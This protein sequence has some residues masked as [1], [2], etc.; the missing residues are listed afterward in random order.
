MAVPG[1][2]EIRLGAL[3]FEKLENNYNDGLPGV[4]DTSYG[5][6]SLRD[7]TQGGN[8]YGGG[9]TYDVT[10]IESPNFPD[11][12]AGFGMGEFYSYDHD[13]QP[14][15][16]SKAMDI[17]FLLDYTFSMNGQYNDT[18]NG[19]KA[20]VNT[21]SNKVVSESG[22]DYR[23]AA[24]L[25]DQNSTTPTYW[26]GNN[27]TVSNLPSANKYN[28]GTVWLSAVVPF[29]NANKTDFDTKIGYIA[30]GDPN[31]GNNSATS[32]EIGTGVGGPEPNDTAI[33]RVLNNSL[34]GS[35]R[36]GVTRMII[37]ITDDSP[38]GD[39]DD[40]FNGA[41]ELANMGTLS[42]QAV[43]NVCTISVLGNFSNSTSS[44][45]TTTRYDIY[46]GYANNTGGLTNFAGDP[47]DIV[48]FIEDICDDIGQ[49]FPSVTT[50]D[51]SNISS[52]GFRMNGNVTA[53]GGSVVSTRGFVKSLSS[54]NLIPGAS[55][56]TSH[57]SGSGTGTFFLDLTGQTDG[58]TF[59]YRAYAVNSTGSSFGEIKSV[60]TLL[61][62]AF[63]ISDQSH[64]YGLFQTGF[65]G[66]TDFSG[67][68]SS[69]D[70][71]TAQTGSVS[72]Q[73][74]GVDY[75]TQI[76]I[77]GFVVNLSRSGTSNNEFKIYLNGSLIHTMSGTSQTYT[78]T[79]GVIAGS[80]IT[81]T[82]TEDDG[83]TRSGSLS[84][85]A[86]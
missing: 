34:A 40:Q 63:Q 31:S 60:T 25:I 6:F 11:N 13:F 17:V 49:N 2:G 30:A 86:T 3:A 14:I 68:S 51:P 57:T 78:R 21:I 12:V 45:G 42:N 82:F 55:G 69:S 81:F 27:T 15:A 22:G 10:N 44:D 29:A 33:D 41:E 53:Q 72:D 71:V 85:Y 39:G 4:I 46:N 80:I 73:T 35:F 74:K 18:T 84:M 28:S 52:F 32:M 77:N 75:E 19:L 61:P 67:G 56:V 70:P 16:C 7:I 58:T 26:T 47:S 36:S 65:A 59:Y 54:S 48:Q 83:S 79:N 37:L 76:A 8:T 50:N 5:P 24:V 9:E 43:A 20:Q 62:V 23:L 1:S 64:Q 38:D 66:L